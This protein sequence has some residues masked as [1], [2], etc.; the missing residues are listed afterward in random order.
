MIDLKPFC[1][2]NH[3]DLAQPFSQGDY[4]YATDSYILVR[5]PKLAGAPVNPNVPVWTRAKDFTRA[6]VATYKLLAIAEAYRDVEYGVRG[7]QTKVWDL[8]RVGVAWF[9]RDYINLL[10]DLPGLSVAHVGEL[11][12]MPFKFN[13][14]MGLLMPVKPPVKKAA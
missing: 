9:A 11:E 12:A 3:P 14:G 5:V 6:E 4:T 8:N 2:P 13:G 1:D 10:A 7:E